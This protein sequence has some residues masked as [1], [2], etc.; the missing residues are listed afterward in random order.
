MTTQETSSSPLL[1]GREGAVATLRFNRPAA[2]NAIDV[3]MATAFLAAARTLAADKSVRA[4]LL[5]GA[6]KGFMAG[7][8]LGVLSA[9]PKQ[10]AADLIG[11]LHEALTVLDAMDAP[12]VAQVHGVAAGAGLSLMLQA[13][14]VLAAEGTRFNLAYVNVGTSCDVGASWALPRLVGM[15]RAL[16][17]A[18]LGDTY[19]TAAA[20]RLGLINRVV[21]AAELDAEAMALAQR[22]AKGPTVAL[23]HLR[24]LMR[25]SLDR[26]LASQL[27]AESAAFQ[28]CAAT[29]DFRIGLDAFFGKKPAAFTGR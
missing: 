26:D 15:R 28:S 23:G 16:E 24:R 20:E 8:D 7:G 4:V 13:D 1:V 21:P 18:M 25:G 10:G 12:L 22:L 9:D 17:I 2:L 29:A 14:F 5:S 6:G 27:D 3:P 19:D 11:P